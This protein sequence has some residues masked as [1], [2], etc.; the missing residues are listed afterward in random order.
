MREVIGRSTLDE[1]LARQN[2]EN[3]VHDL[4]QATLDRYGA[5]VQITQVQLQKV[6]APAQVIDAFRDVQAAR[7]DQER[8]KNEAETYA[9]KVIPEAETLRDRAVRVPTAAAPNPTAPCLLLRPF[10]R[11]RRPDC[12]TAS[13]VSSASPPA[14]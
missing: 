1:I 3:P 5:G 4:M 9:N 10:P 2:I 6:D 7:I 12:S 14:L 13:A 11:A 8:A